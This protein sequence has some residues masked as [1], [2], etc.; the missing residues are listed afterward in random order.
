M[1]VIRPDMRPN[2]DTYLESHRY[3]V[4][5]NLEQFQGGG[6]LEGLC[7][8]CYPKDER[9]HMESLSVTFPNGVETHV[10]DD[11][12]YEIQVFEEE[13]KDSDDYIKTTV[14]FEEL[15][16]FMTQGK[17][18]ST[19]IESGPAWPAH[20]CCA[21][22]EPIDLGDPYHSFRTP[23]TDAGTST[24]YNMCK[25]CANLIRWSEGN[26]DYYDRCANCEEEYPVSE[27]E[28]AARE[29]KE[30]LGKY[31][32]GNCYQLNTTPDNSQRFVYRKCRNYPAKCNSCEVVDRM[33]VANAAQS[34]RTLQGEYLC[35]SC[36][37]ENG[38]VFEVYLDPNHRDKL[39]TYKTEGSNY[40]RWEILRRDIDSENWDMLTYSNSYYQQAREATYAAVMLYNNRQRKQQ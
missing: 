22:R 15:E 14:V 25:E 3:F 16:A 21:C 11:C 32:C 30:M 23:V 2:L 35:D 20:K 24:N 29:E 27:A 7:P 26:F 8:L 28:Y 19:I 1:V 33:L 37:L 31:V 17:L 36:A 38:E 5:G 9:P 34:L 13:I 18:F 39:R 10:C 12:A 40:Y 6:E 4:P